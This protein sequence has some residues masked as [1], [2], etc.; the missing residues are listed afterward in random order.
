M[1]YDFYIDIGGG[2]ALA[3]PD[4]VEPFKIT[5]EAGDDDIEKFFYRIE[6]GKVQ[7]SNKPNLYQTTTNDVYRLFDYIEANNFS[8]SIPI[9]FKVVTPKVT[10]EGYAGRN[11]FYFDSD[12]K[13][14][15]V[16]PAVL[17]K[18]TP[19]LEN[20]ETEVDFDD[21]TFDGI[22]VSATLQA[23]L[24]TMADWPYPSIY[25]TDNPPVT[26]RNRI[27]EKDYDN[28]GELYLYFDGNA[29]KDEL[30][31][32]SYYK[33]EGIHYI[34]SDG[35]GGWVENYTSMDLQQRIDTLGWE[36]TPDN[37]E[38]VPDEYGGWELSKFRV[39]E[40]TRT[41]GLSG[42]RWRNLYCHT[43][44]SRE[45]IVKIDV[46]DGTSDWGYEE[47]IGEGWCMR[48]TRWKAGKPAHL[49]TR[50]PFDGAYSEDW[51]TPV[52][53]VNDNGSKEWNF[54]WNKYV[55]TSLLYDDEDSEVLEY[56]TSIALRDFIEYILQNSAPELANMEFKST[57]FFNDFQTSVPVLTG[58]SGFNYVTGRYNYL[59]GSRVIFGKDITI[60]EDGVVA[61]NP[62]Y[63]LKDVLSDLNKTFANRLT[64]FIDDAGYF[65]IEHFRWPDM[66]RAPLDI[67]TNPLLAFTTQWEYDKAN[68]FET[69][70]YE[71]KNA[72]YP[73][74]TNNII[75]YDKVVSN[76]R[77]K[78]NSKKVS[79]DLFTTDFGYC[80]LNPNK[81]D[82][83]ALI[84]IAVDDGNYILNQVGII[85][86]NDETNGM[87]A[88]S[89][90]L[91]DFATY[92]GMWHEGTINGN[93]SYFKTTDR[94]K[95][96]IELELEGTQLSLFYTTQ[97]GIG[98]IDDGILDLD[99]ENTKIKLRYRYNSN[100]NGDQF[101]LVFQK[102]TDFVGA[103]NNWA[104]IDNYEIT[105]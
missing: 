45:E 58:T 70:K 83:N 71:Q 7:F 88:L 35:G 105:T 21:F 27:K 23:K 69:Y 57:F 10:I 48:G 31:Q 30:Y 46:P 96:G 63:K 38:T 100:V 41:G 9:K 34:Y 89:N 55:E 90:L 26:P 86:G 81:I 82:D 65:R 42:K 92:Q 76:N 44:F 56:G 73:D 95:L 72:G 64:W 59:M 37:R 49:W 54:T 97:I 6:W 36:V 15:S 3:Y 104:D 17:D 43:W 68:M 11:D 13:I 4:N 40:G 60:P 62:A 28:H 85:S 16:T 103:K 99:L 14:L 102:E 5:R 39:Y 47:P 66:F 94:N 91:V 98:I 93:F 74:F 2:Y 18:Y 25:G 32:D 22:T 79:T 61:D 24:V 8:F 87:M 77:N 80:A 1:R 50:K 78:D 53:F 33:F 29:P 20:W 12:R 101:V 51:Q 67:S 52:E 84:L 19:I 75:E